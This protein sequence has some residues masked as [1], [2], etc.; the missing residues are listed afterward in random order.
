M[1]ATRDI[2]LFFNTQGIISLL[3]LEFGRHYWT[4]MRLAEVCY[5]YAGVVLETLFPELLDSS[6]EA[7]INVVKGDASNIRQET[8]VALLS[9]APRFKHEGFREEQEV[10]V[11]AIPGKDSLAAKMRVE[12]PDHEVAPLKTIRSRVGP[13]GECRYIALFDNLTVK[14]PI[15]R[16]IVGPSRDQ[17]KNFTQARRLLGTRCQIARSKTPFIG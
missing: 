7:V 9:A 11:I 17:N 1:E 4:Y 13:A 6:E 5:A 14:L 8:L 16:I 2:V 15:K 12:H 10:R 3:N